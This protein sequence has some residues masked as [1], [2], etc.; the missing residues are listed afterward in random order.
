MNKLSKNLTLY[1]ALVI[2]ALIGM[3]IVLP[4]MPLKVFGLV[5]VGVLGIGIV[6]K[7]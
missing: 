3:S 4:W 2:V 5:M 6:S 1:G 7:F